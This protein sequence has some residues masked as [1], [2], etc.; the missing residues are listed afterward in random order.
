MGRGGGG[1]GGEGHHRVPPRQRPA[2]AAVPGPI[3]PDRHGEHDRAGRLAARGLRRDRHGPPAGAHAV[4][5]HANAPEHSKALQDHGAQFNGT[6]WVDRTNYF[7][8]LP[9]TDENLE[10]GIRLEADR[11]VNSLSSARDL[12]S[13][14]TVVRNEFER[15]RECAD[16][17]ALEAH[18]GGGVRVAQ[19]RQ[20]D[21]R[22]PQRHRARADRHTCRRSTRSITSPTTSC[23]S[24]PG[25]S[26]P[27]RWLS[28]S[29]RSL[30]VIPRP[31]RQ[32]DTTYTEE[33]PQD[34][35]RLV[36]L[37]RVGEVGAVGVA[38]H[39]RRAARGRRRRCRCSPTS[40]ARAVRSLYK[41]GR[42]KEAAHV[43]VSARGQHDPG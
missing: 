12:D 16:R 38:Y 5:G 7:E 34:G 10:F 18:R 27:R 35:E 43:F 20:I 26:R 33:P 41:A 17:R 19:L 40:S 3:A 24:S 39:S 42:D 22:Q 9:A 4:Q 30:S 29:F 15:E 8:T 13:E 11:L 28:V 25:S 21:H 6:T 23:W 32:L 36:T 31:E 37:R 14:M 2:R 1:G